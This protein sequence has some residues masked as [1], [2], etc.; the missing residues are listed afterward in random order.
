MAFGPTGQ[1]PNG[2][3]T[4]HD[5]GELVFGV[6]ADKERKVVIL[7]FGSE[8]RWLAMPADSALQLALSL[9]KAAGEVDGA[10]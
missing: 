6:S 1:F 5:E 3:L 9:V 8:V 10:H 7:Q 4:E 2:K